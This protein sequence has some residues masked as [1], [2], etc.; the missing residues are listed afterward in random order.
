MHEPSEVEYLKPYIQSTIDAAARFRRVLIVMVTASI[1]SFGAFW[2]SLDWTWFN[3]RIV[4][5]RRAE[6]YITLEEIEGQ[7][8]KKDREFDKI[9]ERERQNAGKKNKKEL[10][11]QRILE[12]QRN[13]LI[14]DR[15]ELLGMANKILKELLGG[16]IALA[17]RLQL[18]QELES[19]DHD[20]DRD[21]LRNRM[22]H[23]KGQVTQYAQKLEEM[24]TGNILLIHIPLAGG[25]FDVNTLGLW[26]GLTFAVILLVFRFSLWREYLNLKTTFQAAK[27]EHLEFCYLSLAMQ[28]VLTVPPPL[29]KRKTPGQEKPEQ[30]DA[31][32]F[33]SRMLPKPWGMATQLLYFPPVIIQSL[34]IL[35]DIKT[36][37]I[38][39]IFSP[40]L[41]AA[42]IWLSVA[43]LGFMVFLTVNCLRLSRG[44]D[45]QWRS[46]KIRLQPPE[47]NI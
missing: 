47:P 41:T 25:V 44:I 5:A 8:A 17:N 9:V 27:P 19:K 4:A 23:D 7:L 40:N 11:D 22:M 37:S 3:T 31:I 24:R 21:W 35:N 18:R 38:G 34:I 33:R 30:K 1:L 29:A 42:S 20:P 26:A 13:G 45:R 16:H 14:E 36:E 6:A 2:N 32:R 15:E 12:D 10:E 28:Q 43:L 39:D 46:V